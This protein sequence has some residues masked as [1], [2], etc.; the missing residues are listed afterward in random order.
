VGRKTRKRR[1]H[2][3]PGAPAPGS[4]RASK[5]KRWAVAGVLAA[6]V[7]GGLYAAL[8]GGADPSDPEMVARGGKLYADNC[9]SCHGANLEG[10]PNWRSRKADGTL[11]APPHDRTGHTWH[12]PD[13]LL[14]DYTK[15]GG[16]ANAPPG[17]KSAMPGFRETLSDRDIRAVLAF[18]KSRWP[19]DVLARQ[20][21]ITAR[22]R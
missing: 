11:P 6:A 13:K 19:A 8:S 15:L 10:E 18:I 9:A 17:F 1:K 3:T 7:A 4:G 16:Q 12:H 20:R 2:E 21:Q 22:G 5:A 14:F